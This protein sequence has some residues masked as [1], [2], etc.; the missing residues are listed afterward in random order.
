MSGDL[1]N[2]MDKLAR[3]LKQTK[4]TIAY[5]HEKLCFGDTGEFLPIM[6]HAVNWSRFVAML[7]VK[8]N[9]DIHGKNDVRFLEGCL[10]CVI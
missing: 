10:S 6:D 3:L 9:I 1:R 7:I 4:C 2:C 5:S 8:N